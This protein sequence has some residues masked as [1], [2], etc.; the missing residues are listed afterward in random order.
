M[1]EEFFPDVMVD[2][3]TMSTSHDAAIVAIG[4]VAFNVSTG[5]MCDTD[6]YC[7]VDLQSSI[8]TGGKVDGATVMWWLKQGD[9]ARAA[10]ANSPRSLA[11][12]LLGFNVFVNQ[13]TVGREKARVWGNG[14]TFD[15]VVL[16]SAY[17]R[18]GLELPWSFRNDRCYRTMKAL[19]PSVTVENVGVAHNALH[20]ALY[21]A[22]HLIAIWKT[23]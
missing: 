22:S 1:N 5:K 8:D 16:A 11:T 9:E 3:E 2:L 7:T 18:C 19:R 15:N 6:F 12:A 23:L 21:Q 17:R 14:A 4:A 20:D 10:L 13:F